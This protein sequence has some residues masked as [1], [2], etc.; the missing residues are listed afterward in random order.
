MTA[1]LLIVT[2]FVLLAGCASS[3]LPADPSRMTPEQLAAVAR[4]K[5]AS[6]SCA[7]V[8]TLTMTTRL[9]YVLLDKGAIPSGTV[10]VG[11]DCAVRIESGGA[12]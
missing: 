3:Y 2:A 9:V 1:R 12:P 8:S 7:E 4:D 11:A 6:A 10:T 5:G